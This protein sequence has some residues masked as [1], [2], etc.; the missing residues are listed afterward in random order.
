[1]HGKYLKRKT[2]KWMKVSSSWKKKKVSLD[3]KVSDEHEPQVTK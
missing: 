2:R 3:S 1:M